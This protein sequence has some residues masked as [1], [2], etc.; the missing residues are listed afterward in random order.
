MNLSRY[1]LGAMM[2]LA[3]AGVTGCSDDDDP[4]VPGVPEEPRVATVIVAPGSM[5]FTAIGEEAQFDAAAFDQDGAAIDTV[6]TWQSS[7]DGVVVAGQDGSVL[8]TGLGTAEVYVTAGSAADTSEVTVTMA[9]GPL[10][11]WIAADSGNWD[12]AANWSDDAVPGAGDVAV[13]T[14]IGNYTVTLN[15][16]VTVEALVLGAGSD[17]QTLDTN[18]NQLQF[19]TGGLLDGAEL[20]VSGNLIVQGDLAWSGGTITGS[21]QVEIQSG[22]ELHAVGNPLELRADV[23]NRGIISVAAGTSLRVNEMLE[24]GTGAVIDLQGNAIV[25][26]QNNGNLSNAGTIHKSLGAEEASILASSAEFSSTG[27]L[28]VDTGSL[29]ITGGTL[30]GTIEIDGDAMLNQSG[31]TTITSVN[32]QGDG[33]F[34]IGGKVI[35]GEFE[36]QIVTFRHLILDSGGVSGITGPGSLLIDHSFIWR[37]G[38]VN[39]LGSLNTQV[40]S[41]TTFETT[42]TSVLSAT[43]W[44]IVGNVAGDSNVNLSLVNGAII[45]VEHAGRWVQSAGG[46]VS[47]GQGDTGSFDVIGEFHKTGEGAFVV[48]TSFACSGTMNLVGGTLTVQGAFMLFDSGIMTGGGTEV[49]SLATAQLIVVEAES[50]EMSGTIRPDLDGQPAHMAINGNVDLGSSFVVELD[51]PVNGDIPAESLTFL[52]GGQVLGG[53]LA[54]NVMALPDLGTEYRVVS[55]VD[56]SGTFEVIFRDTNPFDQIIQDERGVLLIR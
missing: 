24:C 48:E 14:A 51:V 35:I 39:E 54:L 16:D 18:G 46:T 23:T 21:G 3:V 9:S 8:A 22:A 10:Y 44:N 25:A 2:L 4:V 49:P 43:I 11:E 6:F 42:G 33:P 34:V 28:R 30:R 29:L 17:T 50:A 7:N 52:R 12:D 41:Q 13:I 47:Q 5:T 45:S 38:L 31:E 55:M 37:R 36:S 1:A 20:V 32:S 27:S 19:A 15:G 53:T 40:G 56:G 26:V